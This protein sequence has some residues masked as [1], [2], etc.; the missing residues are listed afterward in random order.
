M[1]VDWRALWL[2][3]RV[4]GIATAIS[5]VLGLWLAWTLANREFPGKRA[6]RTLVSAALVVPAPVVCCY[7]FW[8]FTLPHVLAAA[9]LSAFPMLVRSARTDFAGLAP[10][11]GRAAR[12]LG[13]SGWRVFTWVELPLVWRP[14][15]AA[16][17]L[18]FARILAELAVT[19][20]LAVP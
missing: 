5:A 14:L 1:P 15:L 4:A 18:A 10:G 3:I 17:G 16:A 13:A 19:R 11:Y 7:L 8:T 9:V 6:V 12:S 20:V 2:G